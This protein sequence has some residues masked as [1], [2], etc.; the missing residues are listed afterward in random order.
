ML[1]A[2]ARSPARRRPRVRSGRSSRAHG[3][4][5][6]GPRAGRGFGSASARDRRGGTAAVWIGAA[7]RARRRSRSVSLTLDDNLTTA[8]SFR[9]TV[10]SVEGQRLAR[11][12]V[13]CRGERAGG[14]ARD[15]T[16]TRGRG[17]RRARAARPASWP[18]GRLGARKGGR[19]LR[20]HAHEAIRSA[21]ERSRRRAGFASGFAPLPAPSVARR[22]SD[23]G[24]GRSAHRDRARHEVCSSR[25]CC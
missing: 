21:S 25:S 10:E 23:S 20:G 18:S 8:N 14:R 1:T 6:H 19:A 24:G 2:P 17:A 4:A 13:R 3:G 16:G 7:A 22:R 5:A 12:I 9:G 11:A 15:A